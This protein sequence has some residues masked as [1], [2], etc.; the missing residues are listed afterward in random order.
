M[1][2]LS[3]CAQPNKEG[4]SPGLRFMRA[5]G[6]VLSVIQSQRFKSDTG[7]F[8]YNFECEIGIFYQEGLGR[9]HGIQTLRGPV[10]KLHEV[11]QMFQKEEILHLQALPTEFYFI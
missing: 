4:Y 1:N 7:T 6:L 3:M 9:D 5:D 2:S 11:I 10:D 8:P